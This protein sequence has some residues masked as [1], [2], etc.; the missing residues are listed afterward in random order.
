M[1]R[2]VELVSWRRVWLGM[3]LTVLAVY[4]ALSIRQN[5][6]NTV[7]TPRAAQDLHSYWYAGHFVRQGRDPYRSTLE[8]QEPIFPVHYLDG[9]VNSGPS[10][11]Q[12]GIVTVPPNTAPYVLLLTPLAFFSWPYAKA[13]W[14]AINLVLMLALPALAWGLANRYG[15]EIG[16]TEWLCLALVFFSL[17]PTRNAVGLGQT[18]LI[19]FLLMATTLL[20]LERP[21]AWA[22]VALGLALSKY[23]LV[24][25]L[26]LFLIWQR[27]AS[28]LAIATGVQLVS[29]FALAAVVR[30][31]PAQV[32][33]GYLDMFRD[34]F[35]RS[36]TQRLGIH[37]AVIFPPSPLYSLG[38]MIVGIVC[39]G[40]F[41]WRLRNDNR[42]WRQLNARGPA[43]FHILAILALW[44]LLVVYHGTHDAVLVL[45]WFVVT[46]H[47]VS[48]KSVR[49][50]GRG[51]KWVV[52]G[53]GGVAAIVLSA[54]NTLFLASP[55]AR[56][57]RWLTLWAAL[58]TLTLLALLAVA[59]WLFEVLY[60]RRSM[61]A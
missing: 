41:W 51:Q 37:L 39:L 15:L 10:I 52:I 46:V 6:L 21:A 33:V 4:A 17:F 59:V 32:V 61:Q 38:I 53:V 20:W 26:L 7:L 8:S 28:V 54:P 24:L 36:A 55:L 30:I 29:I 50:L 44:S 5:V 19:T 27:K 22:G 25:P 13:I 49:P 35:H 12:P 60:L 18:T 31:R 42:G 23:S 40:Y 9:L 2:R 47:A 11:R 16:R 1:M 43:E 34:M 56:D 3:L 58:P 48:K 14:L 57:A 45:L